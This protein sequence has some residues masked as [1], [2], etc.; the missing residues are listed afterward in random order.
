[1]S[2]LMRYVAQ[3]YLNLSE[4]SP[5]IDIQSAET[6]W[7][8]LCPESSKVRSHPFVENFPQ[9]FLRLSD[10]SFHIRDLP[11]QIP[12]FVRYKLDH[13]Y[14][15]VWEKLYSNG[16]N[17]TDEAM[18]KNIVNKVNS[19]TEHLSL[20]AVLEIVVDTQ[21]SQKAFET[22]K[23]II[24]EG[25]SLERQILMSEEQLAN[26]LATYVRSLRHQVF[27]VPMESSNDF[28]FEML[29]FG[30]QIWELF[31]KQKPLSQRPVLFAAVIAKLEGIEIAFAFW[32]FLEATKCHCT[33]RFAFECAL[34][35]RIQ[36]RFL[37]LY[38][39]HNL[40][41]F[42]PAFCMM[43][44]LLLITRQS[45]NCVFFFTYCIRS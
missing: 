2:L 25:H 7:S 17:I 31:A 9:Y 44:F 24:E 43:N 27:R 11:F 19:D 38:P 22:L 16:Y 15:E 5:I 4:L 12:V 6:A 41:W 8:L 10:P 13:Q 29:N 37:C 33:D 14:H 30:H 39:E 3:E 40:P 1:M 34:Y 20:M 23:A 42:L 26:L 32:I 35:E 45:R 36:V 28:E 18:T 21:G